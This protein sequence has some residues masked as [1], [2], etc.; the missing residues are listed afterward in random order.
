MKPNVYT[1]VV[2]KE[3]G[4]WHAYAPA[5]PGC[6]AGGKTRSEALRR[7]RSALRLHVQ[8]LLAAGRQAPIERQPSAVKI[9]IAA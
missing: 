7:F 6:F 4:A 3:A 5:V 8:S 2:E 1:V 9:T